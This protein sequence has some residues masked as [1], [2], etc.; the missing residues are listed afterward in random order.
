MLLP[1]SESRFELLSKAAVFVE[2]TGM[3]P[4][5]HQGFRLFPRNQLGG[6][7]DIDIPVCGFL[8][9]D[10]AFQVS[11]GLAVGQTE[12][13]PAV[14]REPPDFLAQVPT[15]EIAFAGRHLLSA[16]ASSLLAN[17]FEMYFT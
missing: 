6:L 5:L 11:V 10:F 4:P 8:H 1:D 9:P 17:S 2:F 13:V 12:I 7:D 14:W 3:F 16:N 15:A